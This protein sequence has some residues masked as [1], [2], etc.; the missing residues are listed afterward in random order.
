[1]AWSRERIM[2]VAVLLTTILLYQG[3]MLRADAEHFS[4]TLLVLPALIVAGATALPR[5]LGARR[6]L[7]LVLAGAALVAGSLTLIPLRA[8]EPASI[9]A[10]AE[11]PWTDRQ[12]LAAAP[13]PAPPATLAAQR[14]GAGLWASPDCCGRVSESMADFIQLGN[15]LHAVIG[16]RATYVVGF[17]GG[18]PGILYFIADLRPAPFPLD[19][20]TMVLTAAQAAAYESNFRTVV[21]PHTQALVTQSLQATE[22]TAF[23]AH[24]PHAVTIALR[25]RYRRIWVLLSS[26]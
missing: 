20:H 26:R 10:K 11:A 23:R 2:L 12:R 18:Y 19:A 1:M 14:V 6:L 17:A 7:T 8:Y 25:Y 4:G 13:A 3:A 16:N 24:Y 22:A 9:G 21:L 5:L 15:E